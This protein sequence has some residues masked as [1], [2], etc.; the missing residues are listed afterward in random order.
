MTI[1]LIV[2]VIVVILTNYLS[3]IYAVM[4]NCSACNSKSSFGSI[5]T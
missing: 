1:S 5:K 2:S 4:T 3:K